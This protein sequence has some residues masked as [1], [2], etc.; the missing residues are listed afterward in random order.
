LILKSIITE[1]D[2]NSWKNNIVVEHTR[3][4]HF[5]ELRD[6]EILR[7]RIQTLDQMQQYVG[8]YYSKEWVMKNI[9]QFTDEDIENIGK[10]MADE[11]PTD[12]EPTGDEQ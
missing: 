3:D 4:N 12:D 8:E 7:E 2:W 1:E 6:A 11:G 9:L 5:T 10:Q